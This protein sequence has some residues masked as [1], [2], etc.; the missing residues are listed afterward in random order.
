MKLEVLAYRQL[1]IQGKGLRHVA[2]TL[3]DLDIRGVYALVKQQ[4]LTF[5]YRQ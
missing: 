2:D 3:A 1:G 4:S 5:R